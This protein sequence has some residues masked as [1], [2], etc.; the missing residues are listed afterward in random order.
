MKSTVSKKV[1]VPVAP[2]QKSGKAPPARAHQVTAREGAMLILHLLGTKSA[3]P[4]SKEVTRCRISEMTM[5][6]LF[7]RK[8]ISQEF[9]IRVQNWLFRAGWVLFFAGD[10]YAV[11]KLSVVNGWIRIGSKRVAED[12]R[13]AER[14]SFDYKDLEP[15]LL[16]DEDEEADSE[17]E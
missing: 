10:S 15:L 3:E 6:R 17:K 5:R 4:S 14:G 11:V 7:R 2:D 1:S 9:L 16:A 12:L 8:H 13:Q